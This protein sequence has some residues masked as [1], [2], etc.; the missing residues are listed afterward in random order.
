MMEWLVDLLN[1]VSFWSTQ[2]ILLHT[3]IHER[4]AAYLSLALSCRLND[5]ERKYRAYGRGR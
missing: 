5:M 1:V 2:D 3:K 4:L